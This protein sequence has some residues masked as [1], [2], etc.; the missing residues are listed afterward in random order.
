MQC[1]D[2]SKKPFLY[3]AALNY[4]SAYMA[5]QM[6]FVDLFNDLEKYIDN[7][8]R[9][10]KNALRV[11]RGIADTGEP[12]GLYK[13]Q[14]YLEGAIQILRER[15]NIDFI[16]LY[17]GKLSLD[18]LKRPNIEKRVKKEEI[19]LPSFMQNMEEYKK[20]LETIAKINCIT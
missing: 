12:G 11:K 16:G 13:D 15:H 1:K 7:P 14:V 10:W 5:S 19:L 6:S 17:C 20:A 8:R 2:G 3:K 9:R 18:D 4:Y